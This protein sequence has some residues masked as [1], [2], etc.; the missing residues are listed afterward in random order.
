MRAAYAIGNMISIRSRLVRFSLISGQG[1]LPAVLMRLQALH[2]NATI[3]ERLFEI[4]QQRV[5]PEVGHRHVQ[6]GMD[7]WCI[8]VLGVVKIPLSGPRLTGEL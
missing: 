3:R 2:G 6:P 7:L 5:R 4:L 1:E 8:F